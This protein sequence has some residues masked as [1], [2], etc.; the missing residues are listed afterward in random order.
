MRASISHIYIYI[1]I[2]IYAVEF[3][4][5]HCLT[6]SEEGVTDETQGHSQDH[7]IY[8]SICDTFL[9]NTLVKNA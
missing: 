6:L 7:V 1:Y 8:L 3:Y 9:I 4:G 2:Y 5:S